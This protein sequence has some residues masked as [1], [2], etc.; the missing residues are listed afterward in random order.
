MQF[1][2]GGLVGFIGVVIAYRT[3]RPRIHR[4]RAYDGGVVSESWLQQQRGQSNDP[5]R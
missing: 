4:R 1:L 2:I 3:I 5:D